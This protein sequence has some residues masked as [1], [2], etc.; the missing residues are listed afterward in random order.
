MKRGTQIHDLS[1]RAVQDNAVT[2]YN[3][4]LQH[5]N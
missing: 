5:F 1:I 2:G 4:Y 3:I